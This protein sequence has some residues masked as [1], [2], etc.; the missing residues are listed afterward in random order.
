M[1]NMLPTEVMPCHAMQATGHVQVTTEGPGPVAA[2]Q[3]HQA[4]HSQGRFQ[5]GPL[6]QGLNLRACFGKVIRTV[7][8]GESFGELALL[9]KH[10][11]RTA[12]VVSRAPNAPGSGGASAHGVD[13]IKIARKDYDL[14]V[15]HNHASLSA[16]QF[17]CSL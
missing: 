10:A 1:Y 12:T 13:L 8:A 16:P 3:P 9:Q 15:S 14:T 17:P 6:P 4:N 2:M 7:H 5:Q 11:R